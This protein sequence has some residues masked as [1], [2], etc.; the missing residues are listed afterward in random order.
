[1][2]AVTE[3]VLEEMVRVIVDEAD[4]AEELLDRNEAISRAEELLNHVEEPVNRRHR[5]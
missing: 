5:D 4:P 1:M 2:T 3:A